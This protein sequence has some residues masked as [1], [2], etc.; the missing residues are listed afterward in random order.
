MSECPI[1]NGVD[2]CQVDKLLVVCH[3][4]KKS[5]PVPGYRAVHAGVTGKGWVWEPVKVLAEL[6]GNGQKPVVGFE[7]VERQ[8]MNAVG[9][10]LSKLQ[11]IE[12]EIE[13]LDTEIKELNK[14]K[15]KLEEEFAENESDTLKKQ[16]GLLRSKL[17]VSK[18][19]ESKLRQDRHHYRSKD[20]RF[21]GTSDKGRSI[22]Q[23]VIAQLYSQEKWICYMD[24]LY[25]WTGCY[26]KKSPDEIE[27]LRIHSF[28]DTYEI[29]IEEEQGVRI[30]FPYADTKNIA[31]ALKYAKTSCEVTVDNINPPG[32]NC[33]NGVIEFKWAKHIVT[34]EFVPHDPDIHLYLS[35]PN[36]E[37]DP[38]ADSEY[39]DQLMTCLDPEYRDIWEKTIAASFDLKNVRIYRGSRTIRALLLKG[40]GSNGKDTLKTLVQELFGNGRVS[41]CSFADFKQY[42]EGNRF[43]LFTLKDKIVNWPSENVGELS[44]ENIQSLKNVITGDTVY[45]EPKGKNAIEGNPQTVCFF[46]VNKSVNLMTSLTALESRWA[47]IPFDKTYSDKPKNNQEIQ[48]D[49]RFKEDCFF[50]RDFVAP[51][52]LNKL[53]SQIQDLAESGIDYTP[54]KKIMES[55]QQQAKHLLQFC[56]DEKLVYI[57]GDTTPCAVIWTKLHQWYQDNG[58]LEIEE[59]SSV[60]GNK[61]EKWSKADVKDNLVRASNQVAN[62][63]LELF[64]KATIVEIK[65]TNGNKKK[66]IKDIGFD[67]LIEG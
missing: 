37:Y 24:E 9:I 25:F 23:L 38:F 27:R 39:Y 36:I 65:D 63:F 45:F 12:I 60:Y 4:T 8:L 1:C 50:L 57:E 43:S 5:Q 2:T 18:D 64:P 48:A 52:F 67:S 13:E 58:Y 20:K 40:D 19:R 41:S 14:Q 42:D 3:H 11:T 10:P 17:S 28:C 33:K 53:L 21:R 30:S 34:H 56:N 51:S 29:K 62:R 47:I 54:T 66:H 61:K 26:Y 32:F 7:M 15:I 31:E 49:S 59:P 44:I 22:G 16:I 55:M 6:N 35:A 46:N